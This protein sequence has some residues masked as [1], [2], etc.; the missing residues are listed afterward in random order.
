MRQMNR[1]P[2]A[3]IAGAVFVMACILTAASGGFT[4]EAVA[5]NGTLTP[6]AYLPY[7]SRGQPPMP[8]PTS[9]PTLTPTSTPTPTP[10]ETSTPT[11]TNTPTPTPTNTPTPTLTPYVLPNHSHYVSGSSLYIV[12]EVYNNTDDNLSLVKIVAN[13]F[14]SSGQLADTDYTYVRLDTLLAGDKACFSISV[15]NPPGDWAYY[16]FETPTYHITDRELPNLTVL[17]DTGLYQPDGH[18]KTI[19]MIRND[20]GSRVEYIESVGTLYDASG[21][22]VGCRG[23]YINSTHLNPGQASSFKSDFYGRD[24][25]DVASYRIQAD[26]DPQSSIPPSDPPDI[27]PNHSSY[28]DIIDYLHVV[29]EVQNNSANHLC[30]VK[31]IANFFNSGGHLVDTDIGYITLDNLPAGEKT[32]FH[33]LLDE[34]IGWSYYEFETPIYNADGEPLPNLTV[35]ND[36]GSYNPTFGWYTILGLVR[37]DHGT[38]VEYVSPVGTVYNASGVVIG[39][40]YTYVNSTHLDPG[41]TSSFDMTFSGRDYAD[42]TSY[43]LQ[44]DGNPQ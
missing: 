35:F 44:V 42:V 30:S 3:I 31:I 23:T 21:T 33:I 15:Y 28:T 24:Y 27:L 36:S 16:E 4:Y 25:A 37:N 17:N 8:A 41:Q 12:G 5:E 10:T 6:W 26:G 29:G 39:C 22:V 7:V 38:R 19:G 14:N 18:Y 13:L 43:Q 9:I 32:C 11:P 2:V 40:N 34:P 20:H 1:R